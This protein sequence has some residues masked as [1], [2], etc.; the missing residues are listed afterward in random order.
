[1][2]GLREFV[3]RQQNSIVPLSNEFF[4]QLLEVPSGHLVRSGS[5]HS[6]ECDFSLFS[7]DRGRVGIALP[8]AGAARGATRHDRA[9]RVGPLAS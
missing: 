3:D 2:I 6:K 5:F 7:S 9:E 8:A 4:P 1:L